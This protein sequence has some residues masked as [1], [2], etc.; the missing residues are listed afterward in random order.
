MDAQV[1]PA[2][3]SALSTPLAL[4][5]SFPQF[6]LGA[7]SVAIAVYLPR[8]Y[9]THLGVGL[10]TVGAAFTI[11]RLIDIVFDPMIGLVMDKTRTAWG[12]YRLWLIAGAPIV[13]GATYM[14][15]MAERGADQLYL[16]I[17]L[18][19]LYAGTSIIA[20]AHSS[21]AAVIAPKYDDRSRLFS[22]I[23]AIGVVGAT[24]V[25]VAPVVLSAQGNGG[26]SVAAMGWLI[27]I[28]APISVLLATL[29]T[30]EPMEAPPQH[31]QFR[32][33]DYLEMVT[34][35]A[36]ARIIVADFCLAMG[37]G[38]MS[39]LY[40]FFF[41]DYL[42]FSETSANL[43][44]LIYIFAGIIGSI[45]LGRLAT[46]FG[47][48]R[49][50]MGASTLYSLGLI[51]LPLLPRGQIAETG[52]LMF[53]LGSA[54]AGFSLLTRAMVADVGDLVRL[55]QNKQRVG[56]LYAMITS[57]QK[58]AGALSIG[59]TFSVLA[60][61]GYKAD[62]GVVN[63]Q[64]AIDGLFWVYL[65]GPVV[66]V[67]LGGACF[68]GYTLDEKRHAE[69]RRDLEERDALVEE[70]P[71]IESLTGSQMLPD[72]PPNRPQQS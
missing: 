53:V 55:E 58:V 42:K 3:S 12:R 51:L 66:F 46:Q 19:A 17:W 45:V 49:T 22:W 35:P 16:I 9:A 29:R 13:A 27:I 34:Q 65:I 69:I 64:Q 32:L 10:A 20:L 47:K 37:P 50:L 41:V 8:H 72:V 36:M 21:W 18:L 52:V 6:P 5:F 67:M 56:L 63:T 11:V 28:A 25:L 40:V 7:L 14:L 26:S 24:A 1:K 71:I 33:R 61:V 48:H 30:R 62:E 68:F 23:Q 4:L 31:E 59:L 2:Q 15:F 43:L 39:A 54:A 38:W 44:L 70:A 60:W 57:T